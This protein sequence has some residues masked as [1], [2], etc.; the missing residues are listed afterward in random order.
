VARKRLDIDPAVSRTRSAVTNGRR[1]FLDPID[2]RSAISRRFADVLGEIVSDLGGQDAVS[3]GEKQLARRC[4]A[5]S[6]ECEKMEQSLVTG[7][8]FDADLYATLTNALGRALSRIGLKRRAR[9]VTPD[10]Q[11]YVASK[12]RRIEAEAGDRSVS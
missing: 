12:S 2:Q 8:K 7:E 4:A 5:L 1:L 10:L 3:E 9:D 6:V 11:A